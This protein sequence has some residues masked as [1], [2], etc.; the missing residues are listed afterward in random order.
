MKKYAIGLVIGMMLITP[1]V[2]YGATKEDTESKIQQLFAMVASLQEQL[3][4]LQ[5]AKSAPPKPINYPHRCT[6]T[7]LAN[8]E[9]TSTTTLTQITMRGGKKMVLLEEKIC[10]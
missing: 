5:T 10:N 9:Y 4:Q 3:R 6:A 1:V 8:K 7:Q 2:V